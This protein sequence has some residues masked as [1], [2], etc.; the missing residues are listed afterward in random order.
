MACAMRA[1]YFFPRRGYLK[2]RCARTLSAM[3]RFFLAAILA[4]VATLSAIGG[5]STFELVVSAGPHERRNVPVCV[6]MSRARI[7]NEPIQSVTLTGVDGQRVPAQWTG[8][9]LTS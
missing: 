1:F 9:S 7:G 5:S 3:I 8:P 4:Y 2:L 6:P